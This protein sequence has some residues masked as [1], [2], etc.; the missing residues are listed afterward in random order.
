MPCLSYALQ[1]ISEK[2]TLLESDVG[3]ADNWRGVSSDDLGQAFKP[4]L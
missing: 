3:L 4:V 2:L 1:Q